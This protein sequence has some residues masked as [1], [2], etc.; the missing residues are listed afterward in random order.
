MK[1]ALSETLRSFGFGRPTGAAGEHEATGTLRRG[2]HDP[3]NTLGEGDY[4]Q[5]TPIQLLTAYSALVNG[6]QLLTP[7]VAPVVI[8]TSLED[9][10]WKSFL[11]NR[12][13]VSEG[14]RGAVRFRDRQ[15]CRLDLLRLLCF[16]ARLARR[17]R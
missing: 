12:S 13:L 17:R 1:N 5:T 2:N 15:E 4:L 16:L 14:M 7:A 10:S 11:S 9:R 3:R 8:F 6:G